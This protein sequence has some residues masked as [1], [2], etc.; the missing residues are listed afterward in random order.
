VKRF[1]YSLLILSV[2]GV[3][4]QTSPAQAA[5]SNADYAGVPPFV[6][7]SVTPNILILMD[8][9]GSMGYRAQCDDQTNLAVPYN[10]CPSF[11]ETTSYTGLF[12]TLKCYTYDAANTRFQATTSKA[13]INT[14]CGATD[15]DGNFLNWVSFRRFDAV[16]KAMSGG[17][18][19]VARA[20]DG[21]C[22]PTGSPA[23]IT[24]KGQ[25][26]FASNI[27]CIDVSSAP[28]PTGNGANKA[29][30]RVPTAVQTLGATPA[31]LVF[32]VRGSGTLTGSFCVA[33]ATN[34]PPG[35]SANSCTVSGGFTE[36]RFVIHVVVDTQP[37]GVIQE[38]GDNARFGL[39][40]FK[41]ND[42]A[43]V[44]TPI[45]LAQSVDW[46]TTTVTTYSSNK[47]AMVGAVETSFPATNTPLAESLYEG[48]RYVAQV[49]S[50]FLPNSYVYPIAY[51]PGKALGVA[52]TGS[53]GPGELSVLTGSETCLAGYLAGA[54]GR[55]PY[56]FGSNHSPAWASPSAQV[57]CCKTFIMIFTD[58]EPTQDFSIPIA[59]QDYAHSTH[60]THCTGS[61][62]TVPPPSGTC[63][64]GTDGNGAG[65]SATML[66][67]Q[68]KTDYS[69]ALHALDDVAYWGH[70][71][72]L[73]QA[74]IPG[75]NESGHDLPGFQNVT[76][77]TFFA[78]GNI[79]GREIL[80]QAARQGGFD[81]QNG[82]N[83]PDLPSEYDKV[84]NDTGVLVPDGIPD[85]YF[86]SQNVDDLKDKLLAAI[87]S[88]LQRAASGT[89]VS[90]LSTSTTGEGAVYQAYF[91]PTTFKTVGTVTTE[92][93]WTGF[94]QGLFIDAFGNL[95]EDF[96]APGCTG[97]PDGKLVL[98]HDCII[99]VRYDDATKEVLVDRF[100]D[101]DGDGKADSATP[102]QTVKLK[103][104]QAIWEAGRRLALT[105]PGVSCPP[106]AGGV[107]CRRILTW[108]DISNGGGIGPST[109]EFNEFRA[110][111]VAILCPY[112]G[113]ANVLNCNSA[114]AALKTAAQNEATDIINFVRG[115]QVAG[116][117]DRQLSVL[118]DTGAA[119]T[120]VWPLGDIIN[121]TPVVVGAPRE[122]FDIIYGDADYAKFFK[123]YKDRRQVAYVGAND[124]MLHAFNAGF[125]TL[126]DDAST[127][128][129]IEQARFTTTP[130]VSGTNTDC[131]AL[132]CDGSVATYP[133][134][135][136]APKLGA[137]LWGFIPQDLLPHLRWLTSPQY[138]HVYYVDLK[139]KVVDVRI[140]CN[141]TVSI[142]DCIPGQ[143][144]SDHPGGWG[145]VLIGGFR[146][147]GSCANCTQGKAG[148]RVV[149]G[150]FDG[151]GDTTS[152]GDTREFLSSYFVLDITNP[153]KDPVL[154]WVFRDK[155]L[156]LT[157]AAP[158]VLRVNP[159]GDAKTSSTN[160]KWYVVFGT[161]P[162]HHDAGS[163]QTAKFFVVDLK[164]GPSYTAINKTSGTLS[165][166][167]VCSLASP[168]IAVNTANFTDQV[169]VFS[170]GQAGAFMGDAVTLDFDLDFRV[171]VMYLGS[172]ICTGASASP[173][174]GSGP[175]WRGAMYR[176][177]TNGG[178]PDP[179]TWGIAS[180]PTTLLS[181]FAYTTPQATT[182]TAASP[183][184]VGPV[185]SAPVLSAD[186][187]HNLWVFFGTGRYY[188][189]PDKTNQDIQHFFGV[190]DCTI[191]DGCSQASER[192]NLYNASFVTVCIGCAPDKNVS[193]DG[194]GTYTKGFDTGT[195]ALLNNL[196]GMDGWFTTLPTTRERTLS[197]AALIGGVLFFTTFTPTSDMCASS[198]EGRLYAL[199]YMTGTPYKESAIGTSL[200]SGQTVV[201]RSIS[202]GAGM[203]SEVTVQIG[204]QGMGGGGVSSNSG[205][206]GRI[207]GFIQTSTSALSQVCG[208]V[209]LGMSGGG[210][211]LAPWSRMVAWRDL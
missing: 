46:S 91:Y 153:E 52:G 152:A 205:C 142:P 4:L 136:D 157:T 187:T 80:M 25:T 200:E 143:G 6:A 208:Q 67:K 24:L 16:K 82:N 124:G 207:T 117:R 137:E 33:D 32:H 148:P 171:E 190:K 169:R 26:V 3:I 62:T 64:V 45:G 140:F 183:C 173:C 86:E 42:G 191:T 81:D 134:R 174:N 30:G 184:K 122:R 115:N 149:T 119:V 156:G 73:R 195:D 50:T 15:W 22:P 38:L 89:A 176:L 189:N 121:A 177:T 202:L 56:F 23:L 135:A 10:L 106:D 40:E 54:C 58:G 70:I 2:L 88:I 59:L 188:S 163:S 75:I 211:G 181:T 182:C 96:S 199:Y 94:T 126:G 28:V 41:G 132:P 18:C 193:V 197:R 127:V 19:A 8:N 139:P 44:L 210:S 175:M 186:D 179:D 113:G 166:G 147:G 192:N 146:L 162:T 138:D 170:T 101:D 103:E 164:L 68:H 49:N 112:L 83:L 150:D 118:D 76:V 92:V 47:A 1:G 11:V 14:A 172:T 36:Q 128:T 185:A 5:N 20:A 161:G 154:L 12:D 99:K 178:N 78:F 144:L 87:T 27:C 114:T 98:K 100:K 168:C 31:N 71:T 196:Q 194:G 90:V 158:A 61:T 53:L 203:P 151:N 125:F 116:L 105:N 104:V 63:G 97:A 65:L 167:T 130:K 51:A 79:N 72:D 55:D 39:M 198:G 123:R 120:R 7:T 9:S 84:N 110:D 180:A 108:A 43:K 48:L 129:V 21:T 17:N 160:E 155:D 145:T 159:A 102:F 209:P 165:D 109:E 69:S 204:G 131:A 34:N 29:N 95:R 111:R 57:T 37:T 77:Y 85:T 13:A 141:L 206:V 60:G 66:L 201:N 93:K 133:F 74:T 107:G 35:S